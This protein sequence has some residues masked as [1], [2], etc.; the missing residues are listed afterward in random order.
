MQRKCQQKVEKIYNIVRALSLKEK[1]ML[2]YL[3]KEEKDI[4][5]VAKIM[6]ISLA[7]AYRLKNQALDFIMRKF[8]GEDQTMLFNN[9]NLTDEEIMKIMYDYKPLIKRNSYINSKF[10]EDLNQN[11]Q[12]KIYETLRKNRKIKKI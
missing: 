8:I 4:Y 5:E 12:E 1:M 3:Y 9:F 6:N 2:F 11:I 10:D 7:T